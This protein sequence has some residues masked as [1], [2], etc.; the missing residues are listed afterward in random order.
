M[1]RM[2]GERADRVS[3][4]VVVRRVRLVRNHGQDTAVEMGE[5]LDEYEE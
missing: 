1:M 4:V 3:G 5:E 2:I